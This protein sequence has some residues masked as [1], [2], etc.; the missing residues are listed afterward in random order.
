MDR[1]IQMDRKRHWLPYWESDWYA[2]RHSRASL[3][4]PAVANT[5][6]RGRLAAPRRPS[7]L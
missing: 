7:R 5:E 3:A 2:W 1:L 4:S 6:A